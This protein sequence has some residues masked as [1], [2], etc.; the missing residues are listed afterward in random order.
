MIFFGD[1]AIICY[2]LR[3]S[4]NDKTMFKILQH[5]ILLILLTS[6]TLTACG[7]KGPLVLPEDEKNPTSSTHLSQETYV[8]IQL[9]Q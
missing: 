1:P 3:H 7:Q 4:F 8:A 5:P 2:I 9:Q 6:F